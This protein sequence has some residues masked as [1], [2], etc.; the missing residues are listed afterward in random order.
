MA[1]RFDPGRD[2]ENLSK[3]KSGELIRRLHE[4]D[5]TGECHVQINGEPIYNVDSKSGYW[6]GPYNFF[7]TRWWRKACLCTIHQRNKVGHWHHQSV[8]FCREVPRWLGRNE[9]THTCGLWLPRFQTCERILGKC[10][11]RV[12][13][14]QNSWRRNQKTRTLKCSDLRHPIITITRKET[15]VIQ[16]KTFS[17]RDFGNVMIARDFFANCSKTRSSSSTDR[18]SVF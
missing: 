7:G 3:M 17:K 4:H 12:W 15:V 16:W 18:A 11:K 6:D 10:T 14:I 2:Y 8:L 1:C 9:K 13:R 5:P